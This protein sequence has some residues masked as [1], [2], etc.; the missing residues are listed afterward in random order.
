M[1]PSEYNKSI[2]SIRGLRLKLRTDEEIAKDSGE[3]RATVQR[4]IRLNNLIP[5]LLDFTV[6]GKIAMSVGVELSYLDNLSQYE[7]TFSVALYIRKA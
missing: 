4:Y 1:T 2:V 3:S 7:S 6:E 5:E